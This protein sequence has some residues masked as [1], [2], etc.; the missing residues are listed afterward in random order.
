MVKWR[1]SDSH[2]RGM[3][4]SNLQEN[5]ELDKPGTCIAW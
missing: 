1:S 3:K 5:I 4:T 2:S